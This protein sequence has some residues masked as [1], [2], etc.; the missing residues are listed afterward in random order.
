MTASP[1]KAD[2]VLDA[3]IPLAWFFRHLANQYGDDVLHSLSRVTAIVP[4]TWP[5]EVAN[6]ALA[7][8]RSGRNTAS[9][10]DRF[11]NRLAGFP[12]L[13]EDQPQTRT[14]PAVVTLARTYSL[15]A[16][17]AVYL[18]L[19]LRLGLPLATNDRKLTRTAAASGVPIFTP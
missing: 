2:F 8:E 6:A 3:A 16:Y 14:W 13:V 5:A 10:T 15:P 19:A 7:G 9:E 1:P 12:I 18:D 11:L 17:D 4:P